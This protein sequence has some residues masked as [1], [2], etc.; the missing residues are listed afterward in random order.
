M[1]F[2]TAKLAYILIFLTPFSIYSVSLGGGIDLAPAVFFSLCLMPFFVIYCW[3]IK[4][5]PRI[6]FPG[7]LNILFFFI[8]LIGVFV[9]SD[10][11]GALKGA[12]VY[13]LN[14]FPF[15]LFTVSFLQTRKEVETAVK[16][17]ILVGL[18]NALMGWIEFA[19][20]WTTL[21]PIS[22]PLIDHF[23][24]QFTLLR[25]YGVQGQNDVQ[26]IFGMPGLMHMFGFFD[27]GSDTFA[28]FTL[29]PLG[30][31]GYAAVR[32]GKFYKNLALFFLVTLAFALSRNA[33]LGFAGLGT[34]LFLIFS[35]GV[36]SQRAFLRR[37]FLLIFSLITLT[38]LAYLWSTFPAPYQGHTLKH[39]IRLLVRL[40][41]FIKDEN[42]D[43]KEIFI[44]H[45]RLAL[46]Y[47]L[48]NAGFGLGG[49]NFDDYVWQHE[50]VMA[51]SSHSNFIN[52]LGD[53]GIWGFL[54]QILIVIVTVLYGL[55]T[56]RIRSPGKEID[57][58]PLFLTA[59]FLGLVCT[60]IV[61]TFY[62]AIH[63]FVIMGLI[64]KLYFLNQDET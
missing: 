46:K 20:Y 58:L 16:V 61:R 3:R 47:G 55:E 29:I 45:A 22:P 44:E 27:P 18:I 17:F 10:R 42:E 25:A 32:Y 49:Q 23:P 28:S 57:H 2:Q 48:H 56:Y 21:K 51:Y 24:S 6:G 53:Y 52:F 36:L 64:T 7:L 54:T 40:N 9:A 4:Q 15:F 19:G 1:K 26:G 43:S 35:K 11:W 5:F 50:N 38:G 33:Y 13:S 31:S 60:G 30:L 62:V 39:P 8:T 41:P 14:L 34:T 37:S 12:G 63:T 59:I